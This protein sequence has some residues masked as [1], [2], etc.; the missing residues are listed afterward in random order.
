MEITQR[1]IN[2]REI[3]FDFITTLI[4]NNIQFDQLLFSQ[5]HFGLTAKW[6]TSRNGL[7]TDTICY[8]L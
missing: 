4:Q 3:Q 7:A 8:E 6:F 5:T 1:F 2:N